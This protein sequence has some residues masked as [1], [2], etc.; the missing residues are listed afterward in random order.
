M[1]PKKITIGRKDKVDLPE[2]G[3]E[4]IPAKVD[5]GAYTSS[6]HCKNICIKDDVL[7]FEIHLKGGDNDLQKRYET[8]KFYQKK[9]RS[10]NG[11]S[12]IRFVIKSEILLFG[13][14][15][16]T[17]FSLSDRSKMKNPVLLGRKLLRHQFLVDVSKKNLSFEQKSNPQ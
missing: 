14:S 6:I 9:I 7:S 15:F 3:I 13:R 5:T 17:E 2:L 16:V 8:R 10:S 12:E 11:K 4:N 1:K